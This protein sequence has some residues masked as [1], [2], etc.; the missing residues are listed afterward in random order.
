MST[1]LSAV[2]GRDLPSIDHAAYGRAS[3]LALDVDWTVLGRFLRRVLTTLA[4]LLATTLATGAVVA[5]PASA[6]SVVATTTVNVRTGPGTQYRVVGT[7]TRG[8]SVDKLNAS[9]G[10]TKIRYAGSAAW[11]SSRYLTT[12]HNVAAPA[13]T[14]VGTKLTTTAV[15]LRTAPGLSSRIDRVLAKGTRVSVTGRTSRGFA[16]VVFGGARRW[17]TTQYLAV[18]LPRVTGYR[19]A[20]ADLTIRT[21][22]GADFRDLGDIKKGSK[23]AVTGTTQNGRAQIV[24]RGAV[25]WVTARYLSNAAVTQPPALRLPHVV[26]H[27]YATTELNLRSSA[28]DDYRLLGTVPTGT[29]LAITATARNGR[30]EIIYQGSVRWV[31][32]AYLSRTR[33]STGGGASGGSAVERGLKPN[34]IKLHR[35]AMVA[36]P[37]VST[38]YGVRPDAIPDHPNG[39]ALDIMLPGNYRS[40]AGRALGRRIAAWA[41]ANHARLGI[42]YIIWDQHIWN[43]RR[44]SEGWRYMADR[45]SDT[46]N[47]KNHVHVTVFG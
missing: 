43:V 44:S 32:T 31:T 2:R 34:A 30:T 5:D 11:V 37:Q 20:T 24:Y 19:K 12:R 47:H 40:A 10:W 7:L 13:I 27:R 42:E 18:S 25:R 14:I 15:N 29:R 1:A 46:A 41:K 6:S 17:I 9:A 36:F 21:T 23:V 28:A 16:E 38:Y 35:A 33:P 45:G 4:I 39:L 8:Q 26:G 22:S 3:D